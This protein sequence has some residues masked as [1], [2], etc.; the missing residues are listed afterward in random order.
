[1]SPPGT[2]RGTNRGA[3]D[4]APS[5]RQYGAADGCVPACR[6]PRPGLGTFASIGLRRMCSATAKYAGGA[7]YISVMRKHR[8]IS[9][10]P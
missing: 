10:P 7:L 2:D 9:G 4:L 3:H 1:M 8:G 6:S 5:V